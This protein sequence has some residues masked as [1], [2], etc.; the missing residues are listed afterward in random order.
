MANPPEAKDEESQTTV[1]G[2]GWDR[3]CT[4]PKLHSRL[5]VTGTFSIYLCWNQWFTLALCA[6][7]QGEWV[8]AFGPNPYIKLE[9]S[10]PKPI[11]QDFSSA[12]RTA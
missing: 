11:S 8:C 12:Q 1:S 4:G 7:G 5:N 3:K 2:K 6:F 10:E 9:I